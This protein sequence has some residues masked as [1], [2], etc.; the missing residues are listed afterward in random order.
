MHS[1]CLMA[2]AVFS[3]TLAYWFCWMTHWYE[4][5]ICIRHSWEG[6]LSEHGTILVLVHNIF[7][8]PSQANWQTCEPLLYCSWEC[9]KVANCCSRSDIQGTQVT[10]TVFPEVQV[11]C[12]QLLAPVCTLCPFYSLGVSAIFVL[13]NVYESLAKDDSMKFSCWPD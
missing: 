9:P 13:L 4:L 2:L 5:L 6:D 11:L 3:C 8:K 12:Q 7:P 10:G 1:T